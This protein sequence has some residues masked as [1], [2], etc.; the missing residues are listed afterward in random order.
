MKKKLFL[1]VLSF[2]M[3]TSA[4]AWKLLPLAVS[5]S[6][7][8]DEMPLGYGGSRDLNNLPTVYIED[9]ALTFEANHPDY[10]LNIK[11]ATGAVIYTTTVYS[12]M[13]LV[14]LPSTLSGDYE[15]EFVYGY[16]LFTGHI[17]L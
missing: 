2:M 4:F 3:G 10:V 14:T 17:Y 16:W 15:I 13:T 9:Y 8:V 6:G 1:F 12:A 11:D 5:V 7:D